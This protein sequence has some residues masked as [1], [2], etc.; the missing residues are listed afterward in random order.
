M[1]DGFDAQYLAAAD[2]ARQGHY[3]ESMDALLAI[4]RKN[5][6]SRDGAAKQALLAMF[7]LLGDDALVKDYRRQL[8]NVLF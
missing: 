1:N 3:A 5:R 7:E 6:A 4:L 2:L 8:A